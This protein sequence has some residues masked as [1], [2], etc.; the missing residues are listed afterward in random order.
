[1]FFFQGGHGYAWDFPN[2]LTE[3]NRQN[4]FKQL[5]ALRDNYFLDSQTSVLFV[6]FNIYQ[7]DS[8]LYSVVRIV[9]DINPGGNA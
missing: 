5:H 1:M 3:E 9:F 7:P 2:T 4:A 6:D 8:T